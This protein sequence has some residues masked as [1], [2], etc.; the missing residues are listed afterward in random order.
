MF[1]SAGSEVVGEH[2]V[3]KIVR[4]KHVHHDCLGRVDV[5][6]EKSRGKGQSG[7]GWVGGFGLLPKMG[8]V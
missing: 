1:E 8:T 6:R 4:A 3:R 7:F 2:A 5:L